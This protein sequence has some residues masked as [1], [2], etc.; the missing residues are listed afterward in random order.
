MPSSAQQS[1][2]D[3]ETAFDAME[4]INDL[5]RK[6]PLHEPAIR[7]SRPPRR[8]ESQFSV[9]KR[10]C[11]VYHSRTL[12]AGKDSHIIHCLISVAAS[13]GMQEALT[14]LE[15]YSLHSLNL[16]V[17]MGINIQVAH[18]QHPSLSNHGIV[19]NCRKPQ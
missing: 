18:E 7:I 16:F 1:S 5:H 17:P 4:R 9:V 15:F 8:R 3:V 2:H 11:L 14:F 19:E 10:L 6:G 13:Q 12:E